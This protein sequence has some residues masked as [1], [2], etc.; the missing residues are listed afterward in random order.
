MSSGDTRWQRSVRG[1]DSRRA[2][3]L[4]GSEQKM[5]G[6]GTPVAAWKT[7]KGARLEVTWD[8]DFGWGKRNRDG[9]ERER[10]VK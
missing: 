9:V 8:S 3:P 6:T 4:H 2:L 10:E 5:N 7:G 1:N